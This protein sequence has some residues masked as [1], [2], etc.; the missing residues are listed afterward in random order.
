MTR[1]SPVWM[2]MR[3]RSGPTAPQSADASARCASTAAVTASR[4][5]PNAAATPSPMREKITPP[6]FVMVSSR[7]ASWRATAAA[8]AS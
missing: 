2:P 1:P 7:S 8:I 6:R 5:D 4:A 3:A